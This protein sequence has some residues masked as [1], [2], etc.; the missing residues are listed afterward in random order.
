MSTS[1][2][3]SPSSAPSA[4]TSTATTS[5]TSPA[6]SSRRH[7]LRAALTRLLSSLGVLWAAVTVVFVLSRASGDPVA[8]LL[9]EN[10]NPEQ[11]AQ[12][13]A[14]LGLDRPLIVQYLDFL[15]GLVRLDLGDSLLY[16]EP[17][18]S[19]I[20]ERIPAT[21]LLAAAALLITVVVAFLAGSIAAMRRGTGVDRT[22]MGAV[23][24]GQST[25]AFW[26]GILLVLLFGVQ[27]RVL[28]A[29]GYGTLAHLVLP[30]TTLAIFSV[31]VVAR[32]LRSSLIEV[33]GQDHV[34]TARAK[35]AGEVRVLLGHSLR[36]A[37]MPVITVL[38][39]ELGAL[40]GGAILTEQIF[41]WPGIG[42][43]TIDAISFR[44]FPLVQGTVVLFAVTFI[45]VNLL[46]DLSY[47][48]IDP[49]VRTE[50]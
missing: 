31:A 30:A 5:P 33:M 17:V 50:A 25:P 28:P 48:I 24:V 40:L 6:P 21:A 32:L 37:S 2:A 12:M 4:E 22:V 49:R 39:L 20:A 44:D 14:T 35:G 34:R 29:A 46:V 23:L 16:R 43:L 18:T 9:P 45:V 15:G 36:N 26:V 11:V 1:P 27:L 42:R 10:A 7:L 47:A 41:N 38:G 3:P 13:Q 19:L 8:Q